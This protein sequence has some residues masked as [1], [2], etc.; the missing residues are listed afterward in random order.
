MGRKVLEWIA[1]LALACA[2][3]GCVTSQPPEEGNLDP[4]GE[5]TGSLKPVLT[6]PVF[7]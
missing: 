7:L 6:D 4:G 5:E 1:L 2:V 3:S